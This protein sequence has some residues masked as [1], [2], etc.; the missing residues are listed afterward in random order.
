MDNPNQEPGANLRF[1][2]HRIEGLSDGVFAI[3]MTL[4]VLELKPPELPKST[5]DA[6]LL[7]E[8]AK[9]A[10]VFFTFGIS[11]VLAGLYWFLHHA[12]FQ[13]VRHVTRFLIWIN[14]T[15]LMLVSLLPFSAALFGHFIRSRLAAQ[16]YYGNQ[17]AIGLLLVLNW[18]FAKR[19]KLLVE[20]LDPVIRTRFDWRLWI[21]PVGCTG[22]LAAIFVN[23]EYA[24][25]GFLGAILIWRLLARYN[26]RKARAA[27]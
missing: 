12:S 26:E 8:L 19:H 9:L 7:A 13:F 21:A 20:D 22:A 6:E 10:P 14:L 15:Y 3:V 18:T 27:V 1:S 5:T 25:F 4:M 24:S 11:F 2:K 23:A 16:I 17:L